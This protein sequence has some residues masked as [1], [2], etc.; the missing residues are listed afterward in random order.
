[1]AAGA[2]PWRSGAGH[3]VFLSIQLTGATDEGM[4]VADAPPHLQILAVPSYPVTLRHPT[5]CTGQ[6]VEVE[7]PLIVF[8]K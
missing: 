2:A 5:S 7:E 4:R 3:Q 8:G 1:M 6:R